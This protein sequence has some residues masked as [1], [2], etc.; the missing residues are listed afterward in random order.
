M[1]DKSLATFREDSVVWAKFQAKA[2]SKG[3]CASALL[4]RFVRDYL[5]DNLDNRI[6][7]H[8]ATDVD[9]EAM[10]ANLRGSIN[11]ELR[12]IKHDMRMSEATTQLV[13]NLQER[14]ESLEV[15]ATEKKSRLQFVKERVLAA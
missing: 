5:D 3:T 9:V 11:C 2:K 15:I 4:Q 7:S 10:I 13:E 12:E 14:I 1:S 8:A 6:D